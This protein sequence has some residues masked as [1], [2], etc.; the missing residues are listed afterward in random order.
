M[1]EMMEQG[2]SGP[3][4]A[5]KAEAEMSLALRVIGVIQALRLGKLNV[6]QSRTVLSNMATLR[7]LKA[8]RAD[9]RLLELMA[10][11]MELPSVQR[12]VP[13]AMAESYGKMES[14]A[15]GV[16]AA[17]LGPRP[18]RGRRGIAGVKKI[19]PRGRRVQ[20]IVKSPAR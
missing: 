11:G 18:A 4:A 12:L 5:S 7:E 10:W 8:R 3:V 13:A 15:A 6:E 2:F 17:R 16:V 1:S 20:N 19:P 14:L 9:P